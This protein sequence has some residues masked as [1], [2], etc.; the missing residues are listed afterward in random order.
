MNK[1]TDGQASRR[2]FMRSTAKTLAAAIGMAA[3]PGIVRA[4]GPSRPNATPGASK[5]NSPLSQVTYHC[6]ANSETC[7]TCLTSGTVKYHCK[8]TGCTSY[9][10]GCQSFSNYQDDY[11]FTAPACL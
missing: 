7:G 4:A 11:T 6:Y 8:A 3:L 10:T 9:C 1:L 5:S 2:A